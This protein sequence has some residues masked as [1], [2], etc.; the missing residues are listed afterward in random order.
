M[1]GCNGIGKY[2]YLTPSGRGALSLNARRARRR[3]LAFPFRSR[4]TRT[5]SASFVPFPRLADISSICSTCAL[6]YTCLFSYYILSSN[7]RAWSEQAD[8]RV[9]CSHLSLSLSHSLFRSAYLSR[10]LYSFLSSTP[11]R[12]LTQIPQI[13]QTR[14]LKP[15]GI[16]TGKRNP[17]LGIRLYLP[18][19]VVICPGKQFPRYFFAASLYTEKRLVY[20]LDAQDPRPSFLRMRLYM[21]FYVSFIL[22]FR[23]PSSRTS[24]GVYIGEYIL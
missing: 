9:L 2:I 6:C 22:F 5:S 18:I 17:V 14:W 20:T 1:I 19:M 8:H 16:T 13:A 10:A 12:G 7:P 15:S 3:V 21:R 23:L 4:S 24:L 11:A